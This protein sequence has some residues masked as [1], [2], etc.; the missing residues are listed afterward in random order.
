M[1]AQCSKKLQ[2]TLTLFNIFRSWK[3]EKRRQRPAILKAGLDLSCLY[4]CSTVLFICV[5]T[6]CGSPRKG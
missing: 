2:K 5:A 4:Q 3:K 6:F 1:C